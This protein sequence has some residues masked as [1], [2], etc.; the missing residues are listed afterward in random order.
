MN[1]VILI[2]GNVTFQINLDPTIWIFDDRRFDMQERFTGVDG[3]GMEL[4]PFLEH[5]R[6]NPDASRVVLHRREGSPVLL[7]IEQAM[8]AVLQFS[9]NG[10]PIRPDGPAL[11]YLADGSNQNHPI[12]HIE[13]MEIH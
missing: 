7:S 4:A 6:P 10:K 13:R 1:D 2:S 5:A 8:S 11:L 9:R 3:L 12:G